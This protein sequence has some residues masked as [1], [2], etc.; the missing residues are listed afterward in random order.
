MC[1]KSKIKRRMKCFH[2]QGGL[3][4]YCKEPMILEPPEY[5]YKITARHCTLEH[6]YPRGHEN[7]KSDGGYLN[8][9]A[10]YECNHTLGKIWHKIQEFK[11]AAQNS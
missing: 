3:C 4:Y 7:R 6:I 8:V 11:N 1:G 9:A 5:A 2:E 10:C